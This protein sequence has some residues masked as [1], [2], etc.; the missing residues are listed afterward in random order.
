MEKIIPTPVGV[1][2]IEEPKPKVDE[3]IEKEIEAKNK[4][5][6]ELRTKAREKEIE[7]ESIDVKD[8]MHCETC[9]KPKPVDKNRICI[10]C[11]RK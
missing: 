10:R 1:A 6:D 11:R 3:D 7:K 4:E 9:H 8:H 2:K 5:I